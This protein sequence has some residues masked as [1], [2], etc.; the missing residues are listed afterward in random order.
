[1]CYLKQEMQLDDYLTVKILI[2]VVDSKPI[3]ASIEG[4]RFL[5]KH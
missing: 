3:H 1:M 5:P 4:D 2:Q